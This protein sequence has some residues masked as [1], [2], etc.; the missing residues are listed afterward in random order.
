[1]YESGRLLT[2]TTATSY[3]YLTGTTLPPRVY[4]FRV[5]AIDTAGNYSAGA[6]ASLGTP[7]E[8]TQV[9]G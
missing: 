8:L 4:L 6:Y 5:R 2:T 1:V 9:V 7:G 3:V